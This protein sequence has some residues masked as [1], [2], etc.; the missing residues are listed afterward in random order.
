MS[1]PPVSLISNLLQTDGCDRCGAKRFLFARVNGE[2]LCSGCWKSAGRPRG[3][4]L[5]AVHDLE[6]RTREHMTARGGADRH[7]VRSGKS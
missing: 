3:D 5:G 4:D 7:R 2:R 6:V 1:A